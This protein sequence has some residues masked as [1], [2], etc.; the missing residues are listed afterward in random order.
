MLKRLR[1]MDILAMIFVLAEI[2]IFPLIHRN[3][4]DVSAFWCY[5]AIILVVIMAFITARREWR[6]Y[7]IRLGLLFTL[8]ADYFLV[9]DSE[10]LLEG[11]IAFTLAQAAYFAYLLTVEHRVRVRNANVV[12]R[13]AISIVLVLAAILVLGASVDALAIASVIYYSNLVINAVFAFVADRRERTLA[14]ALV[15]FAMC[16]LSIGLGVL[17]DTYLRS[18]ALDFIFNSGFNLAWIFYQ[19][20]QVLIALR[21]YQKMKTK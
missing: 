16:D 8:V 9:V 17:F 2:A 6:S 18:D 4:G 20:S 7:L 1:P 15:L 5:I 3:T 11:V 19:P 13:V 14:I 12:S 10:M 21:T